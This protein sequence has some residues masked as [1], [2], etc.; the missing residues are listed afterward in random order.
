MSR[1]TQD[2]ARV[3]KKLWTALEAFEHLMDDPEFDEDLT[4]SM[5][6]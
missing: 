1:T 3:E 6:R 2:I 5:K 4:A